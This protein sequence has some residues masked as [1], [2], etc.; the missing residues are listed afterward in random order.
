LSF[1][2]WIT[3]DDSDTYVDEYHV[4]SAREGGFIHDLPFHMHRSTASCC[5]GSAKE[6]SNIIALC[7]KIAQN[8]MQ[9]EL[10]P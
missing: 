8:E 9:F 7:G 1:G 4:V 2:F 3:V 10:L 5:D 6:T